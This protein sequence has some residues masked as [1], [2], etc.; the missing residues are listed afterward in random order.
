MIGVIIKF[1]IGL[2]IWL[3]LPVILIPKKGRNK[4]KI[5]T[6]IDITCKIGALVVFIYAAIDLIKFIVNIR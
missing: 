5:G 2:F 4:K 1:I 3:V 6:F